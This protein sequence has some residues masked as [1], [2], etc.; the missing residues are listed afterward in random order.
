MVL[1]MWFNLERVSPPGRPFAYVLVSYHYFKDFDGDDFLSRVHVVWSCDS[2]NSY[3]VLQEDIWVTLP[4]VE[5][6]GSTSF[7]STIY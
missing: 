7:A 3:L 6:Y 1:R 5:V 2:S 4:V